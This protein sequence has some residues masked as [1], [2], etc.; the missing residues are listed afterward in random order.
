MKRGILA[1]IKTNGG[2]Y[3][4]HFE[5][6]DGWQDAL[7]TWAKGCAGGTELHLHKTKV[8]GTCKVIEGK[9]ARVIEL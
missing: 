1:I 7:R 8:F 4:K 9:P 2:E 5:R 3:S 6:A